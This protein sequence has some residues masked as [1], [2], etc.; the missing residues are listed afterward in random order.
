MP[1]I[2]ITTRCCGAP[3]GAAPYSHARITRLDTAPALAMAGVRAVLTQEDVPGRTHFG[4][5][6]Q[7]QPV[8]CDG[9]VRYWGEPIAL[10]VAD[11]EETARRGADAI[12]VEYEQLDPL[13]DPEK[14]VEAGS[15][16]KKVERAARRSGSS[17]VHG[18]G[19]G[20]VHR[21]QPGPG[22][23]GDRGRPGHSRR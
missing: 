14:A 2:S 7:D 11:D 6:H 8:L 21:R 5:D 19:R 4:Q 10:V 18:R 23:A 22:A 1:R 20:R 16:F 3:P 17:R 13:D 9:E 15:Y 12:I